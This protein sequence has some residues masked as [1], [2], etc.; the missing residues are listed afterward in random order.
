[1]KG[2]EWFFQKLGELDIVTKRESRNMVHL[3][4]RADILQSIYTEGRRDQNEIDVYATVNFLDSVS[5][6]SETQLKN[7]IR[8]AG[9][10]ENE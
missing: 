8:A 9:P 5:Q 3:Q 4:E 2:L 6:Y 7:A 10:G 1:M